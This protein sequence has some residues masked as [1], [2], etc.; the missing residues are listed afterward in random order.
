MDEKAAHDGGEGKTRST[1]HTSADESGL[2]R[3][4]GEGVH[5][6]TLDDAQGQ[7]VVAQLRPMHVG[8]HEILATLGVQ[9]RDDLKSPAVAA[10]IERLH[11]RVKQSLGRRVGTSFI[12][13]EPRPKPRH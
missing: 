5:E 11:E 7:A 6:E 9:L 8:P 13:I 3:D 2:S 12:V 1:W 4:L 10:A